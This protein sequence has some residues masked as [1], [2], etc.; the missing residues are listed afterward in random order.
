MTIYDK[1][2]LIKK[3]ICFL[4]HTQRV[5]QVINSNAIK[6]NSD[7]DYDRLYNANYWEA[8][9]FIVEIEGSNDIYNYVDDDYFDLTFIANGSLVII[10]ILALENIEGFGSSISSRF[11]QSKSAISLS[12]NTSADKTLIDYVSFALELVG[13]ENISSHQKEKLDE[14]REYVYDKIIMNYYFIMFN[15]C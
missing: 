11:E 6:I 9:E 2:Q 7:L 3:D 10:F 5:E 1:L 15:G 4:Y 13:N 8:I 12:M 14:A